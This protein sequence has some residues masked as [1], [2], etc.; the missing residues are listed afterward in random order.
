MSIPVLEGRLHPKQIPDWKSIF[1]QTR[2]TIVEIGCGK[3]C[4]LSKAAKRD[5]HCNFIGIERLSKRIEKTKKKLEN[6]QLE[7]TALV[8]AVAEEV[9][10][11]WFSDYP[12]HKIL[13]QCPD[14]WPKKRHHRRRL[15]QEPFISAMYH[16]L[17]PQGFIEINTDHPEYASFILEHMEKTTLFQNL[18]GSGQWSFE[19]D[20][21]IETIHHIKFKKLG[22]KIHY[23]RFQKKQ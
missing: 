18:Y 4:F 12:L 22:R 21:A 14:P 13:I 16:A 10:P 7:N 8:C 23:F 19:T 5:S 1:P 9:F 11:H 15:I 6:F 3:G 20:E 2:P 17:E